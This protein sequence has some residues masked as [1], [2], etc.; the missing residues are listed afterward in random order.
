[1]LLATGA[2]PVHV[3]SILAKEEANV[4]ISVQSV[5]CFYRLMHPK[6]PVKLIKTGIFTSLLFSTS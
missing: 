6:N 5:P 2:P 1:M 4:L 3:E